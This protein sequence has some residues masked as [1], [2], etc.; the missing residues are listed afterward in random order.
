MFSGPRV[1]IT[2]IIFSFIAVKWWRKRKE[3]EGF[4]KYFYTAVPLLFAAYV[5][6]VLCSMSVSLFARY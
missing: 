1:I 3:A 5:V 2:I 4:W 6:L